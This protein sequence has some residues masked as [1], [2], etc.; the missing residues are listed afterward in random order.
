MGNSLI[1]MKSNVHVIGWLGFGHVLN[2]EKS[3]ELMKSYL[4]PIEKCSVRLFLCLVQTMT[5][6]QLSLSLKL[7]RLWKVTVNALLVVSSLVT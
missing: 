1:L 5:I 2:C 3:D 7:V 6:Y 4:Q